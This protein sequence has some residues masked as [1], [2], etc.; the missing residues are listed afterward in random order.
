MY[1]YLE[2]KSFNIWK[3]KFRVCHNLLQGKLLKALNVSD[4]FYYLKIS[5]I[6]KLDQFFEV[7]SPLGTVIPRSDLTWPEAIVNTAAEVNPAITGTEMKSMRK[8][9]ETS[10]VSL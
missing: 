3:A 2:I 10:A 9:A 5:L 7:F 1:R 8:P 4:V 6:N